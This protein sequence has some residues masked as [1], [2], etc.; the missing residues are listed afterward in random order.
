MGKLDFSATPDLLI[1]PSSGQILSLMD[2]LFNQAIGRVGSRHVFRCDPL[3]QSK[4]LKQHVIT[5]PSGRFK[6]RM[7]R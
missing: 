1:F 3:I 6:P 4:L 2:R 7:S 5:I